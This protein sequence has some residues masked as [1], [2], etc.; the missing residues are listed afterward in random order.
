MLIGAPFREEEWRMFG[1]TER[2]LRNLMANPP[3]PVR[4]SGFVFLLLVKKYD[5]ICHYPGMWK[6]DNILI[7]LKNRI[8]ILIVYTAIY[9][10]GYRILMPNTSWDLR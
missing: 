7:Y 4:L 5:Y 2:S 9:I 6:A 10:R 1:L 3:S 8:P